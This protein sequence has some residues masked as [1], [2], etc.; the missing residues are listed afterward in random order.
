MGHRIGRHKMRVAL[1]TLLLL[2]TPV[3]ANGENRWQFWGGKWEVHGERLQGESSNHA[4]ALFVHRYARA[5]TLEVTFTPLQN[6]GDVW[7]AGGLCL[8]Q[9]AGNFWR[10]ALVEAPDRQ[11]RYA[12][13][14]AMSAGV[15]QAQ[16]EQR[17]PVVAEFNPTFSWQWRTPYRLRLHLSPRQ[18]V[19]EVLSVD[20]RLLW[21]RGFDLTN[22]DIV[23]AGWLA[24]NVQGMR[25]LFADQVQRLTESEAQKMR[26]G[27]QVVIVRDVGMGNT[28]LATRLG[29][30]LRHHKLAIRF[31]TLDELANAQWWQRMDAGVLVLPNARRLPVAAK[32]PLM[33]FLREGGKLIAFGAP[34]FAEPLVRAPSAF[35]VSKPSRRWLSLP[36]VEQHRRQTKPVRWLLPQVDAKEIALWRLAVSHPETRSHLSIE[37]SPSELRLPQPALR[38]AFSLKGWAIFIR[39]FAES[40]FPPGHTLTCFWAKGTETTRALMI[41]WREA[42]GSRWFAH[43]PLTTQWRLIVLSPRDFTYR[44]DSPT[45]EKRGFAGDRFN[46]QN[47]REL[48]LGMEAPMPPGDHTFWVA[49]LG[50]APDPFADIAPDFSPPTLEALSPAYKLYPLRRIAEVKLAEPFLSTFGG[51]AGVDLIATDVP[52]DALAPIPRWR[53]L[54]FTNGERA[55][56]WQPLVIACDREETERGALAWLVRVSTLPY[57]FAA[58]LVFGSADETF[59]LRHEDLLRLA[60]KIVISQWQQGVWLLEGGTDRFTTYTGEPLSLY[61]VVINETSEPKPVRVQFVV[62]HAHSI[63]HE[64]STTQ[65]VPPRSQFVVSH[66]ISALPTGS[67]TVIV[68]LM[69]EGVAID[70][71]QHPLEVTERPRVTEAD[72][73]TVRNGH[74]VFRGQRWFAFGVN[75]W[76]RYVAGQETADFYRHWLDPTNYDPK[77]VSDDLLILRTIGMNCVSVQYTHPR[78][79]LPLRDFLRRCHA[80]GIKVNLFIAGAHPL[81]FQP[82]LVRELV[83]AADLPNQPA[84]FA[85]DIAW[86]PHWGN[87]TARRRHDAEWREWLVENYGSVEAAE[88]DWGFQPPRDEKG[89]VTVPRDEHLLSDGPWRVMAAAYR[90]FLD[91]FISRKYREVCRF[92]RQLDP[93]HL[94]GARTGYGGGPFGA[95]QSFP[96]DHTAGAKHLDFISPEGW[97]LGWLGQAS[98]DEFYRAVFIT[99]YARWAGKGKPVFWAEFGL[100]LRHG[101]FSLEWYDDEERLKAQA[102]LYEAMYRLI[103]LSDAD[104]AMAWWFP[105]GYRVDERSDFGIV[106]PDGTLRPAA[107]VAKHWS[108]IFA[109]LPFDPVPRPSPPVPLRI[110]RDANA[111]GPMALWQQFGDEVARL[112]KEGKRV[113]LITDGRG[114]TS[115]DL[116][117]VAVG[118]TPWAPGK[119]PKFLNG[120]INEVQVSTDGKT[121]RTVRKG[122]KVTLSGPPRQ[123]LLRV[124]V[125]NTGEVTW[126]PPAMCREKERGIIVRVSA[127]EE[128]V[129]VPV[130]HPVAPFGDAVVDNIVCP[131]PSDARTVPL[132]ISL[133]WRNAPF[134]ERWHCTIAFAP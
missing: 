76:P 55:M 43:V 105:G 35:A 94:I 134:G 78:Q 2:I 61:A 8:F 33:E 7:S 16:A 14:V 45:R 51:I 123:L 111:R 89:N 65:T 38:F 75:F 48:V 118:N 24:L 57:P 107:E 53:G 77:L 9:D 91:D 100:T 47:A 54:G 131:L 126:L 101:P 133:R 36:E 120:E 39:S 46:P 1:C 130:P 124:E 67:Y 3:T 84:L 121:W 34:L 104:G 92:L 13:L 42:D 106:N 49:G 103:H 71:A 112:A 58:W 63:L 86:E 12:E 108:T 6:I 30:T 85:Y 11:T 40:P 29:T 27:N 31:V 109:N 97:N 113:M 125:G 98:E 32:E 128:Q 70:R 4:F 129:E 72:K 88:R 74:F 25:A 20:G 28:K 115:D 18:I 73:V 81:N 62:R 17:L 110:D 50:T 102:R 44:A 95:E 79:A 5:Q 132:T 56:R 69:A 19:G 122:E 83:T 37:P 87:Y 52:A 21:R 114:K 80:F 96:F 23:K 41:E 22:A 116:L 59:W 82:E 127:G 68:Q 99:A 119:P 93:N 117:D 64:H 15:W 10:L 26:Q 66:G 60:L 90:R